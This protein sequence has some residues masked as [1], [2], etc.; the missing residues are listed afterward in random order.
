MYQRR[1]PNR[2]PPPPVPPETIISTP[3]TGETSN[4]YLEPVPVSNASTRASESEPSRSDWHY[5]EPSE[6]TLLGNRLTVI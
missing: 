1:R 5:Q 3:S 6:T 2:R 4:G